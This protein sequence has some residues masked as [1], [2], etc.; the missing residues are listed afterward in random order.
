LKNI[1]TQIRQ[2][3]LLHFEG[4]KEVEH[5]PKIRIVSPNQK[6]CFD[7]TTYSKPID[8]GITFGFYFT[9]KIEVYDNKTQ[10]KI[11]EFLR[12]DPYAYHCWLEIEER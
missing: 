9:T 7:A 2:E 1:E 4:S 10:E 5:M 3:T 11:F 6:Y 8:D 12:N